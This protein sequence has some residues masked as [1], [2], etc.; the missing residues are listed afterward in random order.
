MLAQLAD[1]EVRIAIGCIALPNE[2]SVALHE[3]FG[4]E[5]V[6]HFPAVGYKFNRWIDVG[7]W[8]KTL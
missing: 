2:A 6:A 5:K 7:Y 4:Y 8:Q 1:T 3:K